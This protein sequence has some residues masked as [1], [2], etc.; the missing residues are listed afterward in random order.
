MK[1]KKQ[2]KK[3]GRV[4][5]TKINPKILAGI[6]GGV[7]LAVVILLAGVLIKRSSDKNV[8]I[9][10]F[11]LSQENVELIK[12]AIPVED[13]INL[14]YTVLDENNL[15]TDSLHK[16]YDLL[17]TWK[18]QITDNIEENCVELPSSV[19]ENVPQPL[20]SSKC[21]PLLFDSCE[22]AYNKNVAVKNG[23]NLPVNLSEFTSYLEKSKKYV[24]SPLVLNGS[25]DKIL[26][27][28]IGNLIEKTAGVDGYSDLIKALREGADF[29]SVLDK[30]L[31]KTDV[32]LKSTLNLLSEWSEKGL[33]FKGWY[34]IQEADLTYFAQ[35][36]QTAAF[37]TFL[38][39]HRTYPW[40]VMNEYESY[41]LPPKEGLKKTSV[42]APEL[43]AVRFSKNSNALRYLKLLTERQTQE[44]LSDES[45]LAPVHSRAR[46]YDQ[47]ADD[48]RF[49][50]SG[51]E[52]GALPDLYN[53]CFQ[54]DSKKA[55]EFA[56]KIRE[57]LVR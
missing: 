12:A 4:M 46:A 44:K 10:F 5:T 40:K 19:F 14:E 52:F 28:F 54:L 39:T 51:N 47:Q 50:V 35:D 23:G 18:G 26:L 55:A 3:T 49:W 45:K 24:V 7:L 29:N 34:N 1:A 17:F 33:I 11:A 32:S 37:F 36:K 25:D 6:G 48:V 21:V 15:K 43:C 22:L 16:K 8:R 9:A 56:Q 20:K 53:A 42:I 31:G 30:K 38:S 13:N 57:F 41:L 27:A 2:Q